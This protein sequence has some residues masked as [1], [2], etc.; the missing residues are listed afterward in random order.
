MRQK[1]LQQSST[2]HEKLECA[3]QSSPQELY[4]ACACTLVHDA[5]ICAQASDQ[6]QEAPLE[7]SIERV[8]VWLH[9]ACFDGLPR[10][11]HC[12]CIA[13]LHSLR[14]QGINR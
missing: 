10:L 1:L 4:Q 14:I 8:D 7:K 13:C 9:R 2:Q 5:W 6:E 12:V 11:T 3:Q